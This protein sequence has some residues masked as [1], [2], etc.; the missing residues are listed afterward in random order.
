MLIESEVKKARVRQMLEVAQ[1]DYN[2]DL[3]LI[4]AYCF[5]NSRR[6]NTKNAK[7]RN[8]TLRAMYT[9]QAIE[10]DWRALTRLRELW[11]DVKMVTEDANARPKTIYEV[12]DMARIRKRY[13]IDI[14]TEYL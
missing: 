7:K 9:Y 6:G 4:D 5:N 3:D 13:G 10:K 12:I 8:A 2:N 14:Q 1:F 11:K